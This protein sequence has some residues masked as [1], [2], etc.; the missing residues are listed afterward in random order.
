MATPITPTPILEGKAA[1]A[2]F[3]KV[4]RELKIPLKLEFRPPNPQVIK[5]ILVQHAAKKRG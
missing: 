3:A 2:F 5:K 1:S 4:E